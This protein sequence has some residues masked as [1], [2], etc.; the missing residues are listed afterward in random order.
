MSTTA[1]K[2]SSTREPRTPKTPKAEPIASP[3]DEEEE[4]KELDTIVSKAKMSSAAETKDAE[5]AKYHAAVYAKYIEQIGENRDKTA[6]RREHIFP[7]P[8]F[9]KTFFL[10]MLD[11][12]RDY[13][14][15]EMLLNMTIT[16]P[17]LMILFWMYPSHL[18]GLVFLVWRLLTFAP[19]FMLTLHVTSHRR[20]F[21]PKYWPLNYFAETFLAFFL[22]L[23]PGFYY[24]HHVMMHHVENNVFPS[25][26]SSTMPHQRDS[27]WGL[28]HYISKYFT[29]AVFYLPYYA[30]KKKRYQLFAFHMCCWIGYFIG[31]AYVFTLYPVATL[32]TVPIPF[33]V[34][35]FA[36]MQG[37]YTQ[38]VFVCPDDPFSNYRLT[39]NYVN[40]PD[41]QRTYNDGYHV[42]HHMNSR[43]HWSKVID[44]FEQNIDK[45][46]DND[47]FVFNEIDTQGVYRH[48]MNGTYSELYKHWVQLTPN[49]TRSPEEF[50]A[51]CRHRLVPIHKQPTPKDKSE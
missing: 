36:L 39:F 51:L 48:V 7:M 17:P 6:T 15:L 32:W 44:H 2:A 3:E 50:E 34:L 42:D 29:H 23:P 8:E 19:R 16:V 12:E 27:W 37:N 1:M 21:K 28:L 13:I 14:A 45:F 5:R 43:L 10:P 20:L 49:K 25:D 30:L 35:G 11:D 38:H 47:A 18:V 46:A 4:E 24:I 41:N 33:I 26:I 31:S 40:H 9:V 22:G